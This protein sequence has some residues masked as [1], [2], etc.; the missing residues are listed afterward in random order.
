MTATNGRNLFSASYK[1]ALAV[2]LAG[3]TL[4]VFAGRRTDRN[5]DF[6]SKPAFTITIDSSN[7]PELAEWGEKTLRPALEEWYPK[8]LALFPTEGWTPPKKITVRYKEN[9]NVPAYA[10]RPSNVITLNRA[11]FNKTKSIGCVIHELFHIVQQYRRAPA[12]VTEG[13]ADYA[14]NYVWSKSGCKVNTRKPG[15]HARSKYATGAN[16]IAFAESKF[17][18]T[19]AKLNDVCR[20]G[21]YNEE[22]FW[23]TNTGMTLDEIE[24]MWKFRR[25]RAVSPQ[26][27]VMTYDI[28]NVDSRQ[29][30]WNSRKNAL[31][32]TIA[33]ENPDVAGFQEVSDSQYKW[34]KAIFP[35]FEFFGR[36]CNADGSGDVCVVAFRKSRFELVESGNFWLSQKP[37]VPG[38]TGWD[39]ESPRICTYCILKDKTTEKVFLFAN[40]LLDRHGE[41]ARRRAVETI[42]GRL[43]DIARKE[44]RKTERRI[45]PVILAG[46]FNCTGQDAPITTLSRVLN[47]AM[48]VCRNPEGSWRT[49]NEWHYMENEPSIIQTLRSTKDSV[50]PQGRVDYIFLAP[51]IKVVE[52]RTFNGKSG[53]ESNYPSDHFPCS[54]KIILK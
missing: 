49:F 32:K 28:G 52:Y 25:P 27:R 5:A 9:I 23:K 45:I 22:T 43:V 47:D 8:F 51:G 24:D 10:T 31:E 34:L 42:A 53:M 14:R 50:K 18:G 6:P 12:W 30:A 48:R 38:S 3:L 44:A 1:T 13:M 16:F 2:S 40:T 54:A 46:N 29:A 21:V 4:T 39:A 19:A 20:R 7:A 35:E 17:P 26:I 41:T 11:H 15:V 36:G 33:S 37:D